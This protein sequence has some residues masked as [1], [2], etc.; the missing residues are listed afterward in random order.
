MFGKG[1]VVLLNGITFKSV[2]YFNYT[3]INWIDDNIHVSQNSQKYHV[4]NMTKRTYY[5]KQSVLF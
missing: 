3:A 5:L 2:K 1:M 4:K